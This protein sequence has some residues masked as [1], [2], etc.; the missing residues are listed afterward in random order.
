LDRCTYCVVVYFAACEDGWW[1]PWCQ[2]ECGNCYKEGSLEPGP[3]NN[4]TGVCELGCAPGF[5]QT[6]DCIERK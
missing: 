5:N 6:K 2:N 4:V 3:C 1:G